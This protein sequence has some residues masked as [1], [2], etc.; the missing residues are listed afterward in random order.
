MRLFDAHLPKLASQLI[1]ARLLTVCRR[2]LPI[3]GCIDI[4]GLW[5]LLLLLAVVASILRRHLL[6]IRLL[7]LAWG[8]ELALSRHRRLARLSKASRRVQVRWSTVVRLGL[9]GSVLS[10]LL[11]VMVGDGRGRASRSLRRQRDLRGRCAGDN[12][13]SDLRSER[14]DL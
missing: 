10:A 13:R 2:L 4:F 11:A 8:E 14:W 9:A 5:R 1:D 6:R 12:T 3:S 7:C